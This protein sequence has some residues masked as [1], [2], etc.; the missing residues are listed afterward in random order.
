MLRLPQSPRQN[1][2]HFCQ[3]RIPHEADLTE[4]LA[5]KRERQL[6]HLGRVKFLS[7]N[8]RL[9]GPTGPCL[10]GTRSLG[11]GGARD[12]DVQ[13]RFGRE[14]RQR[15]AMPCFLRAAQRAFILSDSFF[16]PAA[17]KPLL[18]FFGLEAAVFLAADP[19]PLA[20]AHRA[21]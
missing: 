5:Q 17:V 20:L 15:F 8:L 13:R 9:H 3:S 14:K 16:L 2:P 19:S 7:C 6:Q 10:D 21:L 18:F 4:F 12:A 11:E 1:T